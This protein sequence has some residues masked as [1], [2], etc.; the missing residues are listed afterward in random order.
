V[1]GKRDAETLKETVAD[2]ADRTNGVA[3]A[4]VTTDDCNT[5]PAVLLEQYGKDTVPLATGKP[6][7][8]RQPYKQWPE[9]S[10]YATVN[11]TYKRGGVV[12]V[13][14]KLVY[15]TQG[16]LA[17]ALEASASS[18]TINTAFIERHNGTDRTHNAR[19]VRKTYEFSK[20]LLVHVA[21]SWWV[22]VCYNFELLHRGLRQRLADGTYRHRT[23]AMAIGL[24]QQPLSVADIL[25][26][27]VVG[28]PPS[29]TASVADFRRRQVVG[30]AP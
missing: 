29:A 10:A 16:D 26:T 17:R 19:K 12:A 15:G 27:Q 7:R 4:L 1:V 28:L 14:R 23:P 20:D 5:Y 24:E 8:P 9:G 11:K 22:L 6:G 21:V 13:E 3:P 30:P 18:D 2:F 25:T